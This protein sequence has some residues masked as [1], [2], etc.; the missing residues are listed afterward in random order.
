MGLNGFASEKIKSFFDDEIVLPKNN[1]EIAKVEEIE[2]ENKTTENKLPQNLNPEPDT[3]KKE[4]LPYPFEDDSWDPF[5]YY[6]N[7]NF[8]MGK[9]KNVTEEFTYDEETGNYIFRQKIGDKDYRPPVYMTFEEY[10]EYKAREAKRENWKN[11]MIAEKFDEEKP[12][13]PKIKVGGEVFDRIF[14]G[15]TIDIRPQ[16]SAELIFGVQ[17]NK[18]ENP[19]IPERQRRQ[20]AFDF[21]QKIQLNVV[22]NIGDKLKIGTNYNTEA[23]FD[24]ENEMKLEYNG[25]EDDIIKKIELGNVNLPL[26]GS[27]IT[28]SQSLFGAK[29]EL[30]FGKLTVTSVISQQRGE[31]KEIESSGGAQTTQFKISADNYEANK[32]FLLSQYFRNQYDVAMRGAPI[33]NSTVNVTRL[34]VWVTNVNMNSTENIRNVVAFQDLGEPVFY[35]Q[36]G[37]I[38]PNPAAGPFADNAANSLYNTVTN[39]P[40]IRSFFSADAYLNQNTQLEFSKDY[41]FAEGARKLRQN[42]YTFNPLLGY[43]S[44]NQTLNPDQVLAVAFQ[45]TVGGSSQVFQV[46]EFSTDGVTGNQALVLKLLKSSNLYTSIPMWDLMMKNV[47]S[48]GAFNISRERF[49]LD[50]TYNSIAQGIDIN[51]LPEGAVAG[52]PLIQVMNLDRLNQQQDPVSDGVF[53]FIEG[54]TINSMNGRIYFPVLEPFGNHL[55]QRITGGNPSNDALANRYVFDPLYDTTKIA[56]QQRPELNRYSIRGMYQSSSSSEISL[57][58]MNV[59]QGSVI[60]TAGGAQL[61]ENVDYTVDYTLGRVKIINQAYMEANT[62]IKVSLESQSMFAI[63]SKTLFGTHFD[64]KVNKDFNVGAT[65]MNLTERPLTQKVNINDE[66]M[67]NTIWGLNTNYRTETP[68]LTKLIDKIP[69]FNT[70][71]MSAVN[72]QGEF[73]QLIPGTSR[74]IGKDGVSYI[75]DFEGSQSLIDLRQMNAWFLASTPQ[76]QPDLFPEGDFVNDLRYGYNRAKL[77]WYTI[78]P[79]FFRNNNLTPAHIKDSPQQSN[80]YSREVLETE[81]FPNRVP[82]SGQVMNMPVLDLAYYPRERGQYNFEVGPTAVSSG[83]N[84]EG[85]LNN[86]N[87]RWGGIMR[88][89][90]TQDFQAANIEY[91]QFWMMDPFHQDNGIDEPGGVYNHSGGD[92]YF[93]LG[94]VSEDILRDNRK[95]FENGLPPQGGLNNI[96]TTAWGRVSTLQALVNA[97]DNDP[98]SRQFQDIGLDGLNDADEAT[99]FDSSFVAPLAALYGVGSQ[100]YLKALED[101]SSD[102][103]KYFRGQDLDENEVSILGRYKNY[104]GVEGNS[105]TSENSNEAFPTASTTLPNVEDINRDNTLSTNESYYQYRVSIRPQDMVV[106]RNYI[107][108]KVTGSGT[109]RDGQ[110]ID[111]SWYLFRIPILEPERVVGGIQDFNSIRFMR[112][113]VKNFN[114]SI[115]LRFGRLDLIRGEW[116][117][118][119]FDLRTPGEYLIEDASS[120]TSFDINA[121]NIEENAEKIPVNYVIPPNIDR[122]IDIGTANLRRLNEQAMQLKVC[123]LADGDARASYKNTQLDLL[124]YN[125]IMMFVHAHQIN[126]ENILNDGDISVFLRIGRDYNENYYEYEIPVKLTDWGRYN[127]DVE[128]DRYVVWPEENNIEFIPDEFTSL[129]MKRN[130]QIAIGEASL[131]VPFTEKKGDHTLRVLGNPNLKEV[132]MIMIGVRNPKASGGADGDDGLE[133]CAEVWVNELRLGDFDKNSGW[134]ATARVQTKLADLGTLNL[135]GNISTP[136]FGTIEQKISERQRETMKGYDL[137]ANLELG[138]LAPKKLNLRLPLYYNVSESYID[139]QFNPNDPDIETRDLLSEFAGDRAAQDSIKKMTQTYNKRR[140]INFTNVKIDKGPGGGKP[141]FY[142]VSNLAFT[143]SYNELFNRDINTEF[144]TTRMYKG[145]VGYNFQ[146]TP[147]NIKPFSKNKELNKKEYAKLLT[148]FNFNTSPSKISVITSLDRYYNE[149]QIR[150]NSDFDMIIVPTF[151]KNLTMSRIYEFRYDLTQSLKF[152]FTANNLSRVFEPFGRLDT[153]EKRDTLRQNIFTGGV[154]TNYNHAFNISYTFPFKYFPLTNWI[155]L[156]TRYTGTYDW[157]RAPFA[158]DTLGATIKNS[159]QQQ[160]NGQFN[161]VTLYNKVPYLKKVNQANSGRRPPPKKPANNKPGAKGGK[162]EVKGKKIDYKKEIPKLKAGKTIIIKHKLNIENAKLT[163]KDKKGKEVEGVTKNLDKKRVSFKPKNDVDS[164]SFVV[165]GFKPNKEINVGKVAEKIVGIILGLKNVSVNYTVSEGTILP[166]YNDSTYS[167][168]MNRSFTAPGFGF[169]TGQQDRNFAM[170]A[171]SN[172]WLVQQSALNTAYGVTNSENFNIRANIEPFKDFKMEV[173]ATKTQAFNFTE[174]FR[175]DDAAQDYRSESPIETGNYSISYNM[176]NTAFVKRG[177]N[178]SSETFDRFLENRRIISQ[179]LGDQN[180]N[181]VGLGSEGIYADGYN[182]SSQEVLLPAFLA[183]YAGS[184]AN[185]VDIGKL[186]QIPKPNWRI[187]YNGLSKIDFFKKYFK[188][189]TVSHAYRSSFNV[190]SYTSNILFQDADGDG[191]TQNRNQIS[192]N[193]YPKLEILQIAVSEQFSPLINVDMTWNNSL[194]TKVELKRDRNMALNF[195]DNRLQEISGNEFVIGTGYRFK[196]VTLPF[197]VQQKKVQSDLNVRADITIRDNVTIMRNIEDQQ[198]QITN[199][200]RVFSIRTAADYVINNRLNV[201]LFYDTIITTPAI[202]TSFPTSNTNAGISLRF[203]LS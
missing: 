196:Q 115:V 103:F 68:F 165:E 20:T 154:N 181:S 64:Y 200:Q 48:L 50:I 62:P 172:G 130:R 24:F 170:N 18:I 111:V 33:I 184:D 164:V 57:N 171:A 43:I 102:N 89:L 63:Q 160:W 175:W 41:D 65:I 114:D 188:S 150:N 168:G 84:Q 183:A 178:F 122:Q 125:K 3:T 97:F 140:S 91:I 187:T 4:E 81:I 203:T 26:S 126:D 142:D 123:N 100:A 185:S 39:I 134:A 66:P 83:V 141:R 82:P 163:V 15:N 131:V 2:S 197:T 144:N 158:A 90:D 153:D 173:N 42:E 44:L 14:G 135:A 49:R 138:K 8:Q 166:G 59:P 19:A 73:A 198:N 149:M 34:E 36:T 47:Y 98:Q 76:R 56:A 193:F 106:G 118:Y 55:R 124:M 110:E 177:E 16:G 78:D 192:D 139:P 54:V 70:K 11:R 145:V 71:E 52:L 107:V 179:R 72:F 17:S 119:L 51:Y 6:E 79:L 45:Y 61:V 77:A 95:A 112:M 147:K 23:L 32:H 113:F 99:F 93:N 13:V 86:P 31:R 169:I 180:P 155:T 186:P 10:L 58:A 28:G 201:R 108:D 29:T 53:D 159:Q 167:M 161:M 87:E 143:Y 38:T 67:S 92:L 9:P 37:Y 176:I 174:F 202:S 104:N 132:K 157:M 21:D 27:L 85:F 121:V 162:D 30:Q 195:A 22:G 120:I 137:S 75:D 151:D 189:V 152:D 69:F 25:Y 117:R 80:H 199:G 148:E 40:Q 156:T 101:P 105:A 191:F 116:R 109:K 94:N 46:G 190:A 35:D 1:I 74:A 133:K 129:K 182:G 88:K 128:S 127:N 194:I 136:G 7:R 60:V 146:T 5:P 96:E 12:L